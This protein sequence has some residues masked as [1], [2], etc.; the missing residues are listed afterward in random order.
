MDTAP[1]FNASILI[2][3]MRNSMGGMFTV[4]ASF[5]VVEPELEDET[6]SKVINL[7]ILRTQNTAGLNM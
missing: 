2:A 1:R 7:N 6:R 4:H 5:Q 3:G